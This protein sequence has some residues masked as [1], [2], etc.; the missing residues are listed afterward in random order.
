MADW[1]PNLRG[2]VIMQTHESTTCW[3]G[4]HIQ[5]LL[6][7]SLSSLHACSLRSVESVVD[8]FHA[9]AGSILRSEAHLVRG[10][11]G[12]LMHSLVLQ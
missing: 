7:S 12:Y 5:Y 10:V 1:P 4:G 9:T 3:L 6:A 8:F 2:H 11:N